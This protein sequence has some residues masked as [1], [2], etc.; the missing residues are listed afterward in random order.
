MKWPKISNTNPWEITN[1]NT[2]TQDRKNRKWRWTGH[3]LCKP[4]GNVTRQSSG[5]LEGERRPKEDQLRVIQRER[6]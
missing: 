1:Q 2:I 5:E 4:A 6:V 3:T